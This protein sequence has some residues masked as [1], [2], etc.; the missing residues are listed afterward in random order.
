MKFLPGYCSPLMILTEERYNIR[1]VWRSIIY[2]CVAKHEEEIIKDPEFVIRES[3]LTHLLKE[4]AHIRAIYHIFIVILVVLLCDTVIYDF[5]ETGKIHIGLPTVGYGFGD[6]TRGL[7]LWLYLFFVSVVFH[8]L[9]LI[10]GALGKVFGRNAGT[11]QLWQIVGVFALI[12]THGTLFALPVWDL[13]RE[14][15]A[16][17]SSVAVTC[18]MRSLPLPTF[19]H[20]MYFLF[21][22]TLLTKQIRWGVVVSHFVEVAAIVFYNTFLWERFILPYWSDFGKETSVSTSFHFHIIFSSYFRLWNRVVHS[23]LRD[24]IYMPLAPRTGRAVSTFIV[25]FVS[26]VAHE[27]ILALSFGFFYP[28]LLTQ[29]GVFGL[30]MLPLTSTTGKLFPNALNMYA[31]EFIPNG[32]LRSQKLPTIRE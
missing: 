28:V 13:G 26:A 18:E 10:Y 22:P 3:P 4:S 11:R 24:H 7:K 15:L 14:H 17:G 31:L 20:Y 27:V 25:F 8:P 9:L 2:G 1:K 29:F 23:W 12:A 21:A 16:L 6:V 32:I 19:Q 5:F 30:M